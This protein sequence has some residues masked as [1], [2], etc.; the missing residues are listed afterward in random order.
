MSRVRAKKM[1]G[2]DARSITPPHPYSIRLVSGPDSP[3][4]WLYGLRVTAGKV[5]EAEA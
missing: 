2:I 3:T 1:V 4:D 5:I